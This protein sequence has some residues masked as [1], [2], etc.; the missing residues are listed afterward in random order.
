M[1]ERAEGQGERGLSKNMPH[2]HQG[3]TLPKRQTIQTLSSGGGGGQAGGHGFGSGMRCAGRGRNRGPR[4]LLGAREGMVEAG[5]VSHDGFLIRSGGA[6]NVCQEKPGVKGSWRTHETLQNPPVFVPKPGLNRTSFCIPFH[7]AGTGKAEDRNGAPRK[8]PDKPRTRNIPRDSWPS[9]C[10]KLNVG[11]KK[12][13][14]N[15]LIKHRVQTL[16]A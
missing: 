8:Q 10:D 7:F 11:N 12:G 16:V 2:G 1:R 4:Y 5:H 13:G 14:R 6:N 3:L 9:Y 15:T